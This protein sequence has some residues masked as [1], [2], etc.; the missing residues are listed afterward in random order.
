MIEEDLFFPGKPID[1]ND[2]MSIHT[3]TFTKETTCSST[4]LVDEKGKLDGAACR[5][6]LKIVIHR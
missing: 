3:P 4:P 5:S 1:D 6:F 2:D